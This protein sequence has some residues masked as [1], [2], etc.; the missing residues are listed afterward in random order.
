MFVGKAGV[1]KAQLRSATIWRKFDGDYSLGAISSSGSGNPCDFH[2]PI[3]F[4]SKK[5]SSVD[6]ADLRNASPR[7]IK[8]RARVNFQHFSGPT[9]RFSRPYKAI[10]SSLAVFM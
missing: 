5:S 4:Q 8:I 7:N 2:K 10:I 1:R 3:A 9:K 6:G